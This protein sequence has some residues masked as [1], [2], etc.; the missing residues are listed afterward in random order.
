MQP[1]SKEP[2][3]EVSI[4]GSAALIRSER[5]WPAL[6]YSISEQR[7]TA[8]YPAWRLHAAYH[9]IRDLAASDDGFWAVTSG[10]TLGI[11]LDASAATV[12]RYSAEH[13]LPSLEYERVIV[14]ALGRPWCYGRR[15]GVAFRDDSLWRA[16]ST[17]DGLPS[18]C[19]LS[20]SLDVAGR[21][22]LATNRGLGY[23][24][25]MGRHPLRWVE[26]DQLPEALPGHVVHALDV[27]SDSSLILGTLWGLYVRRPSDTTWLR[28][29][30]SDGLPSLG[31]TS[32]LRVADDSYWIGTDSGL[33]FF[34][35]ES[36]TP[37][38]EIDQ[39][40]ARIAQG[41][42]AAEYWF[43]GVN[44]VW[45]YRDGS[46][47]EWPMPAFRAASTRPT[48]I[49]VGREGSVMVGYNSGLATYVPHRRILLDAGGDTEPVG[50]VTALSVGRERALWA[51][52]AAG[53]KVFS[54]GAWHNAGSRGARSSPPR[55]VSAIQTG[56]DDATWVGSWE[57]NPSGSLYRARY[58]YSIARV[59]GHGRP[60]K[61]DAMVVEP[62]G[63]VL[64]ASAAT[65]SRYHEKQWMPFLDSPDPA[66]IIRALL[67]H[68]LG[69]YCGCSTGL[70]L[71]KGDNWR[72]ILNVPVLCLILDADGAIWVGSTDGLYQLT[73]SET[74]PI[75]LA[76]QSPKITALAAAEGGALWL[77]T[78]MEL[79]RREPS[80]A[81]QTWNSSNSGLPDGGVYALALER[82]SDSLWI[83]TVA[84]VVQLTLSGLPAVNED[85]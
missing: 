25:S 5:N 6:Q 27:R 3:S 84:G 45:R 61:V 48:A 31:I 32:I 52:S 82:E 42:G 70:Y 23:F 18:T 17:A 78:T 53:V 30:K 57:H 72:P 46:L 7:A 29:R 40:V 76:L 24:D 10:G 71:R 62:D 35:G 36:I 55:H 74:R 63:S 59:G 85:G 2:G 22:W 37:V 47:E 43:I 65:L 83:G 51:G 14:D 15:G 67:P 21:L 26:Y 33:A 50:P 68:P 49:A 66:S 58:H 79:A 56:S 69:L 44:A 64:A 16:L 81:L 75:R 39:R 19:I 38:T 34:D 77:G 28:L 8:I 80:G 20:A 41:S 4:A 1:T 60:S 54:R 13:G 11:A 9:S 73:E 12:T